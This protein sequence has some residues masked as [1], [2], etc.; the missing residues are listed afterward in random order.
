MES[1]VA[2][3]QRQLA[4]P[5]LYQRDAEAAREAGRKLKGAEDAVAAAYARWEA[6]EARRQP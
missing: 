2:A 1:A 3:L 4:D 5:A 6:L